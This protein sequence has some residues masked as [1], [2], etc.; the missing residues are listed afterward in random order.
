MFLNLWT[1]VILRRQLRRQAV[2]GVNLKQ[3]SNEQEQHPL[4]VD[5]LKVGGIVAKE[6]LGDTEGIVDHDHAR[7]DEEQVSK[8]HDALQT[9]Y[10]HVAALLA[11][12]ELYAA[13]EACANKLY[14][15]HHLFVP[16]EGVASSTYNH[17]H[18][19]E[20]KEPT[21]YVT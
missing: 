19:A 20:E 14:E 9:L 2:H 12:H 7:E 15:A 18:S 13:K 3:S 8:R 21:L 4:V 5:H 16:H 1:I 10:N 6:R 17:E 11:L